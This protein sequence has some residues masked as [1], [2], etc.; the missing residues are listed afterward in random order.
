MPE[1]SS[2]REDGSFR[3]PSG[4]IFRR[5]GVLYR[6]VNACYAK[7]YEMLMRSGLYDDL[8]ASGLLVEHTDV[9]DSVAG[10][11]D[12][13]HGIIMPREIPFVSYPYE[14]AFSQLKS[15]ALITLEIQKRALHRGMSLKDASAYNIQFV[16][17]RPVFIDTLS[18]D[19]YSDGSPWVA[20]RQFC[21]HFLAPL[22]LM[23]RLDVRLNQLFRIYMDGVPLDMASKLLGWRRGF[24]LAAILHVH[25]H[26]RAQK[27]YEKDERKTSPHRMNRSALSGLIDNLESAVKAMRWRPGGTEWADYYES[28]NYSPEAFGYKQAFVKEAIDTCRPKVVWDLGANTRVFSRLASGAGAATIAFDVD[29]AAVEKNY[30]QVVKEKE[31]NLL[32]LVLDLTNP[33]GGIGWASV[34]RAGLV[35]RGPADMVLAMALIHHLAISN[36]VPLGKI[37]EFFSKLCSTLVIEFV[38]KDDSQAQRLLSSREDVFPDYHEDGFVQ[39]FGKLF[40]IERRAQVS[41]S[42]RSVYIM[43]RKP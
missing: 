7:T 1:P 9:S 39:E 43:Q 5:D 11:G 14:W 26:A 32:P 23:S 34:E 6:Q 37:A 40:A 20:Y 2:Q 25:F 31:P 10:C 27:R 33:S 42:Q 15:A 38:P 13:C 35:E 41:D 29:P 24:S 18:F 28:T 8:V 12:E 4:F 22:M 36:N 16:E 17:G 3:D 30:L 21:Q 19:P